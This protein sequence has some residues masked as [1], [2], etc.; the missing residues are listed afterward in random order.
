MTAESQ[1]RRTDSCVSFPWLTVEIGLWGLVLLIALSL[2]L[3]RLDA[4]PLNADEARGALAAWRWTDGQGLPAGAGYSPALFAGQGLLFLLLSANELTARLLPALAGIALALAPALLRP[5]L[6]RVGAL[7]AGALL[8]LS[9]TAAAV[10]RTASGDGMAALG[11]LLL[12][13]G[14]W[15][16]IDERR[17]TKDE[18]AAQ[19]RPWLAALGVA[20]MLTSSP[21]AYSALIALAAALSLTAVLDPSSRRRVLGAWRAFQNTPNLARYSLLTF[22]GGF[23]L[24]STALGWNL[25]GLGAAAGLFTQWLNGF[26]RWPDSLSVG[27]PALVLVIYEPLILLTGGLGMAL[28][29]WRSSRTALFMTLWTLV[30]LA[31]AVLRPGHGPGDVLLALAPLACLGG[32][33]LDALLYVT[34]QRGRWLN[35]GLYLAISLPLWVYLL[36]NLANYSGRA[37]RYADIHL[38]FTDVSLPTYLSVAGVTLGVLL[39]VAAAMAWMQGA[40]PALRGLGLSTALALLVYT[41]SAAWGVSHNRPADPRELLVLHPTAPEVRLLHANLARLGN[42]RLGDATALDLTVLSDDPARGRGVSDPALVWALRD[43]RQ[44]HF[45]DTSGALINTSAVVAPEWMGTPVLE[46]DYIGQSFP[47][48]RNWSTHGLRCRWNVISVGFDRVRQLDCS[49]LVKWLLYR[50]GGEPPT[51]ERVVL[52][53]RREVV[54]R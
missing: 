11:M 33:T 29:V 17:L 1:L 18:T 3:P 51:E 24:L 32:M 54:E 36:L 13:C 14:V 21:L 19:A 10:S 22:V 49:A 46:S 50:Q 30:A 47:L 38:P 25:R 2:R 52:W 42:E 20:L 53:V 37:W 12:G 45:A 31:L 7:F 23:V 5:Q 34:R 39:L 35:E 40:G 27:Y 6:G 41:L 43:L 26:V 48:R 15:S 16:F 9:P 44:A 4:A 8:A 28:A